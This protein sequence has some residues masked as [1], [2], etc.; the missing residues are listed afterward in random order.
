MRRSGRAYRDQTSNHSADRRIAALASRQHGVVSGAQLRAEGLSKHAIQRR[1]AAG[2]LHRVRRGV[3][4][5]GHLAL[6]RRSRALAAVLACGSGAL[7]SHR[8][9]GG[10]W[11]FVGGSSALEVTVPGERKPGPD[12]L[13]HRS[14]AIH[15]DDRAVIE[16]VPVTSVA[17]TLVDLAEV[18]SERR[19]ADA[20]H[21]AE[22]LRLFD[23]RRV[24]QALARVAGRAGRHAL[25]RVL[26]A[27]QDEPPFTRNEA[28]RLFLELC[29]SHRLPAPQ[30]NTLVASYEVDFI[31]PQA[32]LAVE[33]D[34]G[35]THLTRRAFREDRRRD[36]RLAAL[37]IQVLRVTWAD[38]AGDAATL[39]AELAAIMA[40]RR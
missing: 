2:R 4:A 40:R 33:L 1:L 13:V 32:R 14:R 26:S 8:A 9:A 35:A 28:E 5:L 23:L 38:L 30:V 15:P 3:Y 25:G 10:L 6:T 7:L 31:W 34:G 27:Y 20:V 19:L 18:L 12:V 11:G 22:V 37:G 17:R 21:E 16:A 24:E 36:R 29:A 39:S